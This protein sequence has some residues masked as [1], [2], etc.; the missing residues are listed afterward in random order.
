MDVLGSRGNSR[1]GPSGSNASP[2]P[3]QGGGAAASS[4]V[5]SRGGC[6]PGWHGTSL[7][8]AENRAQHL[9]WPLR[10]CA[11]RL[12]HLLAAPC[13]KKED[14]GMF[15]PSSSCLQLLVLLVDSHGV[16]VSLQLTCSPSPSLIPTLQQIWSCKEH[17]LNKGAAGPSFPSHPPR[18]VQAQ[19]YVR[20]PHCEQSKI[21]ATTEA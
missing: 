15:A 9:P 10:L 19:H 17:T 11:Q 3:R 18:R 21:T 6:L 7:C 8:P 4:A 16:S 2:A 20:R 12:P 1:K 14:K 13:S 5:A